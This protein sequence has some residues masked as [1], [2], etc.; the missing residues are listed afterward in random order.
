MAHLLGWKDILRPI[1]DG[2]RHLFPTPDTGPT[3]EER[4]RQRQVDRLKGFAYFDTFDQLE[5]WKEDDSDPLQRANTPLLRG[6]DG[7]ERGGVVK[8]P[9]LLIHDYSGNYHD[10]ESVNAVDVDRE[11]YSCEYLQ[12]VDT[13]IYFSH[14]L[15]CVPPP[16]WINLL[17]RNGVEVLGT[18]LIEPQTEG[19][20]RL[21]QHTFDQ[22]GEMHFPMARKLASIATHF[23]FD[24]W[25]VNIEKPFPSEAWSAKLLEAFLLQLK[26]NLGVG[27]G[28]GKRLI[29]YD[30][31]TTSNKISYQNQVNNA[32]M[33]FAC[34]CSN[35]LTNYCWKDIDVSESIKWCHYSRFLPKGNI[36][37][38]VDVWAQNKSDFR[39]P[40]VTWPE[41]GGGGTNTGM[42]VRKM[43][44]S[45]LPWPILRTAKER[46]AGSEH[47]FYTDFS[48]AFG[49]YR[50]KAND[51]FDGHDIHAQ[52]GQQSVL[53]RPAILAPG[54]GAVTLSHRIE[55]GQNSHI[56]VITATQNRP[57]DSET[58]EEH[59]PL[60]KLDMPA[61]GSLHL[62]AVPSPASPSYITPQTK[63]AVISIYFKTTQ[64]TH[65]LPSPLSSDPQRLIDQVPNARIRELGV[66]LKGPWGA[67]VGETVRVLGIRDICITPR[68]TLH[69]IPV[70][71]IVDLKL[72]QCGQE[73]GEEDRIVR[74][75]WK[76]EGAFGSEWVDKGM[77]LSHVTGPMAWFV[78]RVGEAVVGRVYALECILDKKVV[79][80]HAGREVEVEVTGFGFDG[81]K[82]AEKKSML[83]L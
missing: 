79:E 59:L 30:A 61:D 25:L 70:F 55:N 19:S 11:F 56:L 68:F 13:F 71:E 83:Q 29:W 28:A 54:S 47:L 12:F 81:Y 17:H 40:R 62:S 60:Y 46:V 74:L 73:Q 58:V 33:D 64:G 34:A 77:V 78:V 41:V 69:H 35:I 80:A 8:A 7:I 38:G 26:A 10:Y 75:T 67:P 4:R 20:E 23:G 36:Y 2:Y 22:A 51:R 32:N 1:R 37:F 72:V 18:L 39:H 49:T 3:P 14:K 44:D 76:T 65:Y 16:T 63:D 27:L 21:S 50:E 43:A 82:L 42:A 24:G 48:R 66:H 52:L 6:T 15:A 53:P 9:V 31:L 45:G 57:T 5:S